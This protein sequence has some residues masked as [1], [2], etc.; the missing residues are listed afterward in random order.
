MGGVS[1]T[2]A[3]AQAW[4]YPTFQ[5]PHVV[6]REF[7]VAVADGGYDGTSY[8]FQWREQLAS[9]D[10]FAFDGG[11]ATGVGGHALAFTGVYYGHQ[12]LQQRDSE[13]I[14]A[15]GTLGVT[16]AFGHGGTYTRI[17]LD[18][19]IGH[20]FAFGNGVA[21]T[22]YVV[23][24]GSIEFCTGC[25][26][27]VRGGSE[28]TGVGGGFGVGANLEVTPRFSVRFDTMINASTVG[29]QDNAIGFGVAWSPSGLRR[30]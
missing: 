4:V 19:S 12:L 16:I 30:P 23:P 2:R 5:Q 28:G 22:P 17:P 26:A 6:N 7:T 10:Q 11:L 24:R 18:V 9:R 29:A 15:L 20:R 8:L 1:G 25:V 3:D 13:P 27:H 14:E 21:L